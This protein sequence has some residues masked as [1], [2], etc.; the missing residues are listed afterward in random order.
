MPP[1][2]PRGQAR[3]DTNKF[4]TYFNRF[5]SLGVLGGP[6]TKAVLLQFIDPQQHISLY[7]DTFLHKTYIRD[8]EMNR[9]F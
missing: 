8:L 9:K 4:C 7:T 6:A 1:S 5:A 2:S 3:Q